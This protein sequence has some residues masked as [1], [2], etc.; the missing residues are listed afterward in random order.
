MKYGYDYE[1][2]YIDEQITRETIHP[3]FYHKKHQQF[4]RILVLILFHH[5]QR[6]QPDA[7]RAAFNMR[8]R[9]HL[10]N[11]VAGEGL[12]AL[13]SG[14]VF[15]RT[16]HDHSVSQVYDLLGLQEPFYVP[17]DYKFAEDVINT[18]PK[19]DEGM[20]MQWSISN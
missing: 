11:L 6:I 17:P 9:M 8:K 14:I 18:I 5:H 16:E 7:V 19:R 4:Q 2:N 20:K 3:S 1:R 10:K 12:D 13:P 15:F